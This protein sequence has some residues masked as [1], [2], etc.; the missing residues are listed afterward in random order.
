M[1]V[2]FTNHGLIAPLGRHTYHGYGYDT[3]RDLVISFKIDHRG[4]TMQKRSTYKLNGY[5]VRHSDIVNAAG[6]AIRRMGLV[7]S[8][9]IGAKVVAECGDVEQ[10][11]P[12]KPVGAASVPSVQLG[13]Q[14]PY[15]LFSKKNQCSQYFFKGT[16]VSEA[17]ER[18]AKRGEILDPTEVSL[19][20][21]DTGKIH[22]LQPTTIYK[23]V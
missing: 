4:A 18:F 10:D 9:Y 1:I 23:L 3:D 12:A 13:P 20:N 14:F 11:Q 22:K 19:L 7:E 16:T 5:A 15:V 17:L 21:V 6:I 8:D 2:K